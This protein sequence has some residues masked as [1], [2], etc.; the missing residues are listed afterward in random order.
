[1]KTLLTVGQVPTLLQRDEETVQMRRVRM[2][3][4]FPKNIFGFDICYLQIHIYS[5]KATYFTLNTFIKLF[6]VSC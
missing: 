1:M 5:Y 3:A 4:V 6:F 2:Y